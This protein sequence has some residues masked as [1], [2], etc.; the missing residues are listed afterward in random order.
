MYSS[1]ANSPKIYIYDA[2][3]DGTPLHVIE[4]VHRDS[5]HVMVVSISFHQPL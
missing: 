4:K 5:V 2:R 1:D 3:G